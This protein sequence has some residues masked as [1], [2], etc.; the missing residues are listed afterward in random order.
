[1]ITLTSRG[2]CWPEPV[3]SVVRIDYTVVLVRALPCLFPSPWQRKKL[4]LLPERYKLTGNKTRENQLFFLESESERARSFLGRCCRCYPQTIPA[5]KDGGLSTDPFPQQL[6]GSGHR[7]V[8][9]QTR[10]RSPHKKLAPLPSAL[11]SPHGMKCLLALKSF[12]QP[13]QLMDC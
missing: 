4:P 12:Q 8:E 7:Q 2:S 1:M 11:I 10:S 5:L 3:A 6:A 13:D 9:C